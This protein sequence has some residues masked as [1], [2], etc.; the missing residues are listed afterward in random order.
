MRRI[1]TLSL[2]I[3]SILIIINFSQSIYRLWRKQDLLYKSEKALEKEKEE[4]NH[5]KKELSRVES[6]QFIEKEARTK[7]FMTEE[8]ETEILLPKNQASQAALVKASL[9][10]PNWKKWYELFFK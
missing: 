2:L 3:G 10:L 8:G 5:L 9:N 4:N 6:Q 7:L 1:I